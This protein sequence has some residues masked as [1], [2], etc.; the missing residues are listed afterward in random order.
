M[1]RKSSMMKGIVIAAALAAAASGLARADDSSMNPFTGDSYAYFN[2]GKNFPD[3]KPVLD[4]GP[5]AYR[6]TP[7][8]D[9]MAFERQHFPYV[10][11]VDS[12]AA[13]F[14]AAKTVSHPHDEL[15][16]VYGEATAAN[17]K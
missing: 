8:Q 1:N 2:G 14:A 16:S 4:Y 13:S 5:S 9:P 6:A 3:G 17:V 10:N 7:S 15:P 11:S 12:D